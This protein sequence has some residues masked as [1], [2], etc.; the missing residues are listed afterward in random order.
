M[1]LIPSA[2]LLSELFTLRSPF[3]LL[4]LLFSGRIESAEFDVFSLGSFLTAAVFLIGPFLRSNIRLL[5]GIPNCP[6]KKKRK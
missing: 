6:E 1:S 2:K 5:L 4:E 3:F